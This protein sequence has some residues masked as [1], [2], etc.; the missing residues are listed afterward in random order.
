MLIP[1]QLAPDWSVQRNAGS[2]IAEDMGPEQLAAAAKKVAD[3]H[4]AI[5]KV[6]IGDELLAE[7]YP[8][9][10]SSAARAIGRRGSSTCS[11]ARKDAPR[12][13]LVGKGVSFD[14]GGL[15]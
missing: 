1:A 15:A 12:L 7:N 3:A 2:P 9:S 4:G 8:R 11:G 5:L 10:T 13:T 14:T 6:T